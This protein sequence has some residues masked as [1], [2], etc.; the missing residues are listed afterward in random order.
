MGRKE[1]L[2]NLQS[3]LSMEL[4]AVHQYQL[5]AAVLD[6]WGMNRL[7]SKMRDEMQEE[8]GHSQ[9]YLARIIFL[10]G[11][12]ELKLQKTPVR[13]DSLKEMFQLDLADE[14]EAIGFY[15]TAAKQAAEAGDLGSRVLFERIA[16]DEEGHIGWLE[17]QLDL[18]KRMGEPAYIAKHIS[19]PGEH[20]QG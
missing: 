17:L 20:E 2:K 3:A 6:D 1:T 8:L 9:E 18:L 16:L 13:A 15:T 7:A 12:P 14:Q 11:Q 10:K 5:H 19:A 4:T